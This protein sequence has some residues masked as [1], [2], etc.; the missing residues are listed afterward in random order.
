MDI[1]YVVGHHLYFEHPFSVWEVICL[2]KV[3]VRHLLFQTSLQ[4]EIDFQKCELIVTNLLII[5]ISD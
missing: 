5:D 3:E 2:P 4:L 1:F